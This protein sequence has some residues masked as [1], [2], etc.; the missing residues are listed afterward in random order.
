LILVLRGCLAGAAKKVLLRL[1]A[2]VGLFGD[3]VLAAL[4]ESLIGFLLKSLELLV[5]FAEIGFGA[6][7]EVSASGAIVGDQTLP[8]SFE[9]G[10]QLGFSCC[11]FDE[12]TMESF[13]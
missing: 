6:G 4:F 7:L 10:A 5:V 3:Q 1:G 2:E 13:E 11:S 9:L 8:A 12:V